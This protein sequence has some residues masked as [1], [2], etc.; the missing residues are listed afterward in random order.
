MGVFVHEPARAARR[1]ARE[2]LEARGAQVR[3]LRSRAFSA[4]FLMWMEAM[5][6]AMGDGDGQTFAEVLGDGEPIDLVRESLRSV[7]G[8][9]SV[10]FP[11]L[12]LAVLEQ[13]SAKLPRFG[14]PPDVNEMRAELEA[15]LGDRGVILHPPYTRPAPRHRR[16]LL[17]P[18]DF[19]CSGV[20]SVLQ[21]P[22]TQVPVGLSDDGLPV[23]VQ[24][25]SGRGNDRLTIAVAA[26]LEQDLGGWMPPTQIG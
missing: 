8:R 14:R 7:V 21:F 24:V 11:A 9:S 6:D 20:F 16:A 17:T 13:V 15:L 1:R 25:A 22:V 23:G 4:G 18:F 19:V 2:A 10:T 26:A 5:N 3:P 12:A